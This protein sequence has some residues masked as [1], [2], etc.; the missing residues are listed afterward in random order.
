VQQIDGDCVFVRIEPQAACEACS[1]RHSCRT[2]GK[3]EK[4]ISVENVPAGFAEGDAVVV[5]VQPS[6][7]YKAVLF[8]FV[9]PFV[10]VLLTIF[11][12]QATAM[13]E[14][15]VGALALSILFPYYLLLYLFRKQIQQQFRFCIRKEISEI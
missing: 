6:M 2:V 8:A 14:I 4:I 15:L 11:V 3:R 10:L 7:G 9:I 5:A 1:A 13:S 12:L